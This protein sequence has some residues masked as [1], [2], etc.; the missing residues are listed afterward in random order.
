MVAVYGYAGMRDHDGLLS[1][2]PLQPQRPL[3]IRFRL[4]IRGQQLEVEITQKA[5]TYSLRR[6]R[7]LTLSHHDEEIHVMAGK[8]VSRGFEPGGNKE[9]KGA[10]R[11]PA[12]KAT[13][14]KK[15]R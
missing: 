1:F 14:K 13:P 3:R 11:R 9:R 7:K 15:K 2:R 4:T 10:G 6:G 5:V 8:R 12:G